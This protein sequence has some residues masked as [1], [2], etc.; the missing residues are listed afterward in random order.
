MYVAFGL[1]SNTRPFVLMVV[2]AR[3]PFSRCPRAYHLSMPIAV[4]AELFSITFSM[5][6]GLAL[7]RRSQPNALQAIERLA[8]TAHQTARQPAEA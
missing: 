7:R 3:A 2:D 4:G 5:A 6:C 1:L 8:C